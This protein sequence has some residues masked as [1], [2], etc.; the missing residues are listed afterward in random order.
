MLTNTESTT[1][2]VEFLSTTEPDVLDDEGTTIE[3]KTEEP[4]DTTATTPQYRQKPTVFRKSS[5]SLESDTDLQDE[6]ISDAV[7]FD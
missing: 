5:S 6:E 3:T 7:I 2:T 4:E 1:T